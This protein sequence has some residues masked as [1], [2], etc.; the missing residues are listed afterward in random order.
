MKKPAQGLAGDINLR[1]LNCVH[2]IVFTYLRS[3]FSVHSSHAFLHCV[4]HPFLSIFLRALVQAQ[5]SV[6]AWLSGLALLQAWA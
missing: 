1:S 5:V 2:L 6:P 3:H 4:H